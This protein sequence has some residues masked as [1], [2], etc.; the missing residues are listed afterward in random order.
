[1]ECGI[2]GEHYENP[3]LHPQHRH[4]P[5][6]NGPSKKRGSSLTASVPV[7][8]VSAPACINR[9]WPPLRLVSVAQKSSNHGP[10]GLH[11][12]T[13]LD[14]QIIEWLLNTCAEIKWGQAVDSNNSLKWEEVPILA[15]GC[16]K[17]DIGPA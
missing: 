14:D 11:G 1:M 13:V 16:R 10:H 4:P 12:L 2:V 7:S 9:V 3:Y 6:W 5:S 15:I 8:H 17:G